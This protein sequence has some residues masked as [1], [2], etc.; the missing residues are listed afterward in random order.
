MSIPSI[1]NCPNCGAPID[2]SR[3]SCEYCGTPY[4]K[5]NDIHIEVTAPDPSI[6]DFAEVL[7]RISRLS[8]FNL[9]DPDT[10]YANNQAIYSYSQVQKSIQTTQQ[11]L[12]SGMVS[13]TAWHPTPEE[14]RKMIEDM[15]NVA[16]MIFPKVEE[17]VN[18]IDQ[19]RY[20]RKKEL[21]HDILGA[22]I[23]F[24]PAIIAGVITWF[25]IY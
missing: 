17:R 23:L 6:E 16:P 3:S 5:S 7:S 20:E 2:I 22:L 12:L 8:G 4:E 1:T 11:E 9:R 14:E 24:G 10:L 13:A 25:L 18:L 19:F 15:R 21:L